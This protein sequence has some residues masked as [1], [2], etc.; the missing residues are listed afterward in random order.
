VK[1]STTNRSFLVYNYHS[2]TTDAYE[3]TERHQPKPETCSASLNPDQKRGIS[4]SQKS[5]YDK[6]RQQQLDKMKATISRQDFSKGQQGMADR[7]EHVES[8]D[9]VEIRNDRWG[10]MQAGIEADMSTVSVKLV[11]TGQRPC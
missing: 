6:D 3:A 1:G 2:S 10:K 8:P 7:N 9:T 5:L 4:R 11:F